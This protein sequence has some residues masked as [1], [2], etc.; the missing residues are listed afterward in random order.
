[1]NE[2]LLHTFQQVIQA[3]HPDQL[4]PYWLEKNSAFFRNKQHIRL[5]AAGKA[6]AAMTAAVLS[7]GLHLQR[8]ICCTKKE[9]GLP[10]NHP[11]ITLIEAGH[12]EPDAQSFTAAAMV[13]DLITAPGPFD[14]LL[15]LI[16]GGASSLLADLPQGCTTG[17]ISMTN[18][19]LVNSGADIQAINTVRKH[20]SSLKGGQLATLAWPVPVL[21]L[22]LSDV[23]GDDVQTI[24][25][26]LTVPDDS[27]FSDALSIIQQY[28]LTNKLPASVLQ[29]LQAGAA[30]KIPDTP[31]SDHPAFK[32][33]P[34]FIIGN[35]QLAVGTAA[36][37]AQKAGI[38]VIRTVTNWQDE[39]NA[40]A[41]K[42]A[43]EMNAYTGPLPA[44]LIYGGETTL[45]VTGQG[46][47]GRNQQ[48]ALR[49]LQELHRNKKPGL[50]FAVLCA[51]TDGT[52]GPTD[53]AGALIHSGLL[54]DSHFNEAETETALAQFNVY[55]LLKKWHALIKTGPTQTNVMDI[56]IAVIY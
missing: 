15:V 26:G 5:I 12:P 7:H 13:H 28:G 32:E 14:G 1:M 44:C 41:V 38:H 20:L 54:T 35:N 25:S 55:P 50:Q 27:S 52:D 21:S 42:I 48:L 8:G 9:H 40:A 19:L 43:A 30:G 56:L 2:W 17:E 10:L 34:Y 45:A 11:S 29:Y 36:S 18:K 6:A 3:C 22:L 4:L 24:G 16:S 53:A 23:P 37:L 39:C 31:G 51:G 49:I 33:S 47:G 46:K